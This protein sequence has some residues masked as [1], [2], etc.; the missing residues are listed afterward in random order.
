MAVDSHHQPRMA[1][2]AAHRAGKTTTIGIQKQ[3]KTGTHGVRG[4]RSSGMLCGADHIGERRM[5]DEAEFA[6]HMEMQEFAERN[7]LDYA[8]AGTALFEKRRRTLPPDQFNTRPVRTKRGITMV[9][10]FSA[11]ITRAEREADAPYREAMAAKRLAKMAQAER[12]LARS[13]DNDAL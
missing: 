3:G 5:D 4:R 8:W 11:A 6:D 1:G 9:G 12:R 7:G 2:W 13:M 10:L